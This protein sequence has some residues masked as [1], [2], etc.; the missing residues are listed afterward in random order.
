MELN[1]SDQDTDILR[2]IAPQRLRWSSR[3]SKTERRVRSCHLSVIFS[4]T[5][6]GRRVDDGSGSDVGVGDGAV[7]SPDVDDD[8]GVRNQQM[9]MTMSESPT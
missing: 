2:R 9:P 8:D 4:V 6:S 3:I 5:Q 1:S 7:V